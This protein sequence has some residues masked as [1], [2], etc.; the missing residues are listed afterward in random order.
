[1]RY[2]LQ[3][4]F[5]SEVPERKK[6]LYKIFKLWFLPTEEVD[7]FIVYSSIPSSCYPDI[8][9]IV[10]HNYSVRDYLLKNNVT[11]STIV[12]ITCDGGCNFKKI[13]MPGKTLY[14]PFQNQHNLVDL[15]SGPEFGFNFDITESELLLYNS[16]NCLPIEE[17]IAETFQP[18]KTYRR[19]T[20]V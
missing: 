4:N 18:L 8:L 13:N 3:K 2:L 11:E 5:Q 6:Y 14:L 17:R 7:N 19:N 12:A 1:M 9:F 16:P 10:G 15:L 20:K